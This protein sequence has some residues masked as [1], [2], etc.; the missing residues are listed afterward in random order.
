MDTTNEKLS[1]VLEFGYD[2][3]GTEYNLSG[4]FSKDLLMTSLTLCKYRYF[5]SSSYLRI[6]GGEFE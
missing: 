5:F 4:E 2:Y 3:I 1:V 6:L